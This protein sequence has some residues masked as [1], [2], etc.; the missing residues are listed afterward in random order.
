MRLK[1]GYSWTFHRMQFK[2]VHR[3]ADELGGRLIAG[4]DAVQ[5]KDTVIAGMV[6]MRLK[7]R[8]LNA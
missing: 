4:H 7:F 8:Q 5:M 2:L 6:R 3:H 1:R